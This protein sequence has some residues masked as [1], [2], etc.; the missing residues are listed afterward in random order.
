MGIS[1]NTLRFVTLT[2]PRLIAS[3]LE[4]QLQTAIFQ[5]ERTS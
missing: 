4:E 3:L 1:F 5:I 2:D